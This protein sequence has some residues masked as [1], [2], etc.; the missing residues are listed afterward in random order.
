[1]C[2]TLHSIALRVEC[3]PIFTTTS[4]SP[5]VHCMY[6]TVVQVKLHLLLA[7]SCLCPL[8]SKCDHIF[9]ASTH[10]TRPSS[11]HAS[12]FSMQTTLRSIESEHG[13][14]SRD[15]GAVLQKSKTTMVHGQYMAG[16]W[17]QNF[18]LSQKLRRK[19]FTE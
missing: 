10:S 7:T 15:L 13:H 3:H 12:H 11:I 5:A 8:L 19:A 9:P 17:C 2:C 14:C 16:L 18:L 4:P 6:C 1:M